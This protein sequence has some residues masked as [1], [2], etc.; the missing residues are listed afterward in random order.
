MPRATT[1]P[2]IHPSKP[3]GMG[4][5]P[6]PSIQLFTWHVYYVVMLWY[7]GATL[8]HMHVSFANLALISNSIPRIREIITLYEELSPSFYFSFGSSNSLP[9]ILSKSL[10]DNKTPEISLYLNLIGMSAIYVSV[11]AC[12][13]LRLVYGQHAVHSFNRMNEFQLDLDKTFPLVDLFAHLNFYIIAAAFTYVIIV[14]MSTVSFVCMCYVWSYDGC[15][16]LAHLIP[17]HLS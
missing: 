11:C 1:I 13:W 10:V 12:V 5:L 6:Y 16:F 14:H 9:F 3:F 4:S 8:R 7:F 15:L 2:S 17:C